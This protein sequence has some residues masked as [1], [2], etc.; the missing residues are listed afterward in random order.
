MQY[1]GLHAAHL[2]RCQP[3]LA[4]PEK[5]KVEEKVGM[6]VDGVIAVQR[7]CLEPTT[8]STLWASSCGLCMLLG[9]CPW[10]PSERQ[11]RVGC[12][13]V[14]AVVIIALDNIKCN[15]C[16]EGERVQWRHTIH[17]SVLKF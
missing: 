8:A 13:Y 6:H 9:S 12:S 11:A 3:T 1:C 4:T 15:D 10:Q 14:L 2:L 16:K 5:K 7:L 17:V